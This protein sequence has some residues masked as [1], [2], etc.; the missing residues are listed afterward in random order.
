MLAT[1]LSQITL[2]VA[3]PRGAARP[4]CDVPG[5]RAVHASGEATFSL[6][7]EIFLPVG[8]VRLAPAL[9]EPPAGGGDNHIAF[10]IDEADNDACPA[11]VTAAGVE[12]RAPRPRVA[13]EGRSIYFYDH[14]NHLFELHTGM[15]DERLS[16]HAARRGTDERPS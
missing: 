7:P 8:D 10:S 2:G 6:S 16:R 12:L 11:R 15:L 1:G 13:G 5:A 14:G 3:D 4:P 9:G